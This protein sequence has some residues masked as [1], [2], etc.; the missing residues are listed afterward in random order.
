MQKIVANLWYD[1]E[2]VEA[3]TFY[4]TLFKDSE[5]LNISTIHDTPSGDADIVTVSLAGQEFMLLSGGPLFKFNPSI[6]FR[7]D[8]ATVEEVVY[9]W[10]QL[11]VGGKAL[12]PLGSYPFSEKYF[13]TEDKYGL[14]WQ[15]MLVTDLVITQKITPT[16]MFSGAQSGKAEEAIRYYETVFNKASVNGIARYEEGDAPDIP[17]TIKYASF[18]LEGQ[19]FAAMDSARNPDFTFNEAISLVVNCENQKEIDHFWDKLSF[20]PEAEQCGWLKD[21]FGVSWQI[22]PTIMGEMMQT[23]DPEKSRRV[24]EAFL[25]MKKIDIAELT[26][27]F[28][29]I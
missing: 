21:Q 7:V 25:K 23:K 28:E 1:Q 13:W 16:L 2:A 3:A 24:T 9:L 26:K 27:A 14:S 8:C 11:S 19:A 5:I 10:D 6:S 17:G 18:K 22:V 12:M 4:S 15:V 29:V 20:V